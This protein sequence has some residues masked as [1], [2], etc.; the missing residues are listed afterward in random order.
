MLQK[1]TMKEK[2]DVNHFF[3]FASNQFINEITCKF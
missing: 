3:P 1:S 2:G